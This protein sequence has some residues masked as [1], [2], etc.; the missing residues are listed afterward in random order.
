MAVAIVPTMAVTTET[1][2]A[3]VMQVDRMTYTSTMLHVN[4]VN[5]QRETEATLH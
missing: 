4:T 1:A 2:I 3:D 5:T